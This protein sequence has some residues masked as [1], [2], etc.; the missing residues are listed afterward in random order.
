M[1]TKSHS[2]SNI[3]TRPRINTHSREAGVGGGVRFDRKSF[4][5]PL[6]ATISLA[7]KK[8]HAKPEEPL[9]P[10]FNGRGASFE[11]FS[12]NLC[13]CVCLQR[14]AK[15]W[16]KLMKRK[17]RTVKVARARAAARAKCSPIRRGRS[18]VPGC[19][20]SLLSSP[21][22][23]TQCFFHSYHCFAQSRPPPLS[24][25]RLYHLLFSTALNERGRERI[26]NGILLSMLR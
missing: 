3:N 24:R 6:N 2:I 14:R 22:P 12:P 1:F 26:R 19:P 11:K 18:F 16:K 17:L 13:V 9:S 23:S 7:E 20:S 21:L 8:K 10:S 15:R 5:N 4:K 25:F